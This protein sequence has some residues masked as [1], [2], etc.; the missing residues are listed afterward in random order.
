MATM[1]TF[2]MGAVDQNSGSYMCATR[3]FPMEP[4]LSCTGILTIEIYGCGR[5]ISFYF[6]QFISS[7]LC[8]TFVVDIFSSSVQLV[9]IFVYFILEIGN[10]IA[11]LTSI[12]NSLV[13]VNSKVPMGFSTLCFYLKILSH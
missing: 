5:S 8:T 7:V 9:H 1:P 3:T 6:L 10:G 2:Y 4:P 12:L 11:F 13:L